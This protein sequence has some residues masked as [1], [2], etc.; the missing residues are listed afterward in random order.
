MPWVLE[1]NGNNAYKKGAVQS[2]PFNLLSGR[3][4][5]PTTFQKTAALL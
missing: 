4:P 2:A 5:F 3:V 1:E